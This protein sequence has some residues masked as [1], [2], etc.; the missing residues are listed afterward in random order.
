MCFHSDY[1]RNAFKGRLK[2]ATEGTTQLED[3]TAKMLGCFIE[4]LYS[5]MIEAYK[6]AL[7][8]NRRPLAFESLLDIN[9][10]AD[11]YDVRKLSTNVMKT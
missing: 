3:I 7:S 11:R 10:F 4:W 1:F 2:E 8:E 6:V 9:I 5:Q